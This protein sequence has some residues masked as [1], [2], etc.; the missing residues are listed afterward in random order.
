MFEEIVLLPA[1]RNIGLGADPSLPERVEREKLGKVKMGTR[2]PDGKRRD[3]S[4]LSVI[5]IRVLCEA[6]AVN[7]SVCGT[8]CACMAGVCAKAGV[9]DT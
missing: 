4:T 9:S 6:V 5:E 2:Y 3:W 7:Y 8:A 1:T